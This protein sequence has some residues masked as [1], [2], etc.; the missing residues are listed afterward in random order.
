MMYELR[1]VLAYF[2]NTEKEVKTYYFF[3]RLIYNQIKQNNIKN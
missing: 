3:I 2:F 1:M